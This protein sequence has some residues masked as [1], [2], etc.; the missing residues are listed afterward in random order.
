MDLCDDAGVAQINRRTEV[1]VRKFV[2]SVERPS[3][4][5]DARNASDLFVT[6]GPGSSSTRRRGSPVSSYSN[7]IFQEQFS[8]TTTVLT[9]PFPS[10]KMHEDE[11]FPFSLLFFFGEAKKTSRRNSES[12]AIVISQSPRTL[13]PSLEDVISSWKM[14][15][16]FLS[17]RSFWESAHDVHVSRINRTSLGVTITREESY[18]IIS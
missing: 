7:C 9:K 17:P 1:R 12:L 6:T 13:P 14:Q 11:S 16:S 4:W 5:R 10:C 8:I 2:R 15:S 3:G 18:T